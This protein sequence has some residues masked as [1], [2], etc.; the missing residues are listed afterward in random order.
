MNTFNT[1]LYLFKLIRF[2]NLLILGATQA[3]AWA[4]I[5]GKGTPW[6]VLLEDFTIWIIILC[7]MLV[8]AAGYMI[9][10]Y[11]DV[12]IDSINRSDS[13]V[14][15][16][17]IRRRHV[18]FLHTLCNF[19]AIGLGFLVSW[20]FSVVLLGTGYLLWLYSNS[21][22]RLPLVGNLSI[23]FL[24]SVSILILS[25]Y[26]H[27]GFKLI[28]VFSVFAFI[29]QVMRELIKDIEDLKGDKIF[30]CRTFPIVF[31]IEKTK[32]LLYFFNALLIVS[33]VTLLL[34]LDLKQVLF[35]QVIL[36][37]PLLL[38]LNFKIFKAQKISHFTFL[39]GFCKLIILVGVL[40]MVL[41]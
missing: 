21:L 25:L 4:F 22:K 31:G 20:K 27:L 33:I 16:K 10:D 19:I 30:G 37:F 32:N 2:Q 12:K 36:I 5:I 35:Y 6:N 38:F 8:A 14:I 1:M 34:L 26:Y 40:S 7:T 11:Y 39:S 15:D 28:L 23:A 17:H 18:L 41:A 29:I 24:S 3:I 9:N 13:V